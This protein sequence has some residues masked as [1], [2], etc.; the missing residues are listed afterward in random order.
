MEIEPHQVTS[1]LKN[2]YQFLSYLRF[3]S[4][5]YFVEIDMRH[6]VSNYTLKKFQNVLKERS[7]IRNSIKREEE[8]YENYVQK[9]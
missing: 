9:M 6:L 8:N 7:K 3:E 2:K 5:I 4:L 1:G